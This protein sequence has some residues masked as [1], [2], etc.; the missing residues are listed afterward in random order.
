ME[1]NDNEFDRTFREKVLDSELGFEEAAWNSLER[2]LKK[3]ERVLFLRKSAVVVCVLVLFSAIGYQFLKSVPT[4]QKVEMANIHVDK[5][6]KSSSPKDSRVAQPFSE[7]LKPRSAKPLA[8]SQAILVSKYK[9]VEEPG[10]NADTIRPQNLSEPLIVQ[11]QQKDTLR[12]STD[13]YAAENRDISN[14]S[15]G[16]ENL[17]KKPKKG[18]ALSLSIL[19]GPEFN[20]VTALVGGKTGFGAGL[21]LRA[22]ITKKLSLQ[23]GARYS[24]KE[25]DT[26]GFA[27]QFKSSRVQR[28]ISNIDASC[29]VVEIPVLASYTISDNLNRSIDLNAGIS[30]YFMLTEDY[31]FQYKPESGLAD[32]LSHRSNENQHLLGVVDLSATYYI[33][34][35]KEK[36]RLGIE[37]F[38]K[39]PLSGVGAGKVDLKSNGI[40]FKLRYDLHK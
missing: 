30:S 9:D 27:Y 31:L 37:P 25:Y 33:K 28:M 26:D 16:S 29:T 39:I 3:R 38:L 15:V 11:A 21:M 5:E 6:V 22:G 34:L 24:K 36:I 32:R 8:Q 1:L 2:R 23:T 12:S 14:A 17:A 40:S 7:S 10:F 35:K 20:S 19:A 13:T 4:P 18:V